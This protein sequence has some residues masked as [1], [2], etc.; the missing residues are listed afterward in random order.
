MRPTRMSQQVFL[1]LPPVLSH[2]LEGARNVWLESKP[3]EGRLTFLN[4]VGRFEDLEASA[5]ERRHLIESLGWR[6]AR[7]LCFRTGFE[8]GRRDA[9][10]HMGVFQ[11]NVRL[12]LQAAP[13]FGQLQ[14]R[15][16]ADPVCFEFDLEKRTLHRE[17]VFDGSLEAKAHQVVAGSLGQCACW[18]S[19]GFFSGHVSEILGRRVY[20]LETECLGKGDERC[21]VLAHFEPEWGEEADW[22]RMAMKA[23]TLDEELADAERRVALAQKKARQAQLKL[24]ALTS[25]VRGELLFNDVVAQS[26][27]MKVVMARAEQV[28]A[29]EIPVLLVGENGVGRKTLARAIHF[30]G[31]RKGAP[32]E[33]LDL[34]GMDNRLILQELVGFAAGAFQGAVRGH[35]GAI[36]RAHRGTLYIQDLA[37]LEQEA[38]RAVFHML[39]RNA[40]TG[41]GNSPR[42]DVSVRLI[43]ATS[44]EPRELLQEGRLRED[45]YYALSV[46]RIDIPPLRERGSDVAR[47]AD[48]FVREFAEVHER[49]NLTLSRECVQVLQECTWP[50]NVRQ[51]RNVLEQ[52]VIFAQG[53][54]LT[55]ADFPEDVVLSRF[56][57]APDELSEDVI[58]LALRKTRGNRSAAADLLGVGRTTLW[59]AMRRLNIE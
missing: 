52:A 54:T 17:I 56:K 21:R 26:E 8:Q 12:A 7:A 5:V 14:G 11:Q 55:L 58:R 35:T 48:A 13:V 57:K 18:N 40:V 50:G 22:V 44:R 41:L 53:D 24:N 9:V 59:R 32:F 46:A 15:Y 42:E 6:R 4:R 47:M 33:V 1:E 20:F 39:E 31:G 36:Q 27:A 16:V 10:R 3:K 49:T 38:Q 43:A 28:S 25:R 2:Y 51:L 19:T 23:G 29:S 37:D 30:G 34:S 45:L